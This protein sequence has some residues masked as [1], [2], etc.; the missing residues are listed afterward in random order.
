MISKVKGY[1]FA[2][3]LSLVYLWYVIVTS[4]KQGE[5]KQHVKQ[6]EHEQEAAR[7]A[8]RI[9]E[10]NRLDSDDDV[11]NRMRARNKR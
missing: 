6:L 4:R 7:D 9:E 2:I 11:I 8:K 10:S 5:V 1:I 3:I